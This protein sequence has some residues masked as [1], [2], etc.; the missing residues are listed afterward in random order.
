MR[1][2]LNLDEKLSLY[3]FYRRFFFIFTFEKIL[4]EIIGFAHQMFLVYYLNRICCK[5]KI[6]ICKILLYLNVKFCF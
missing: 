6:N 2:V 4:Q 1:S 5:H 3:D